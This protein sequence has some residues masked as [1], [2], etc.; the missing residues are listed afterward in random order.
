MGCYSTACAQCSE[1]GKFVIARVKVGD[2][3]KGVAGTEAAGKGWRKSSC[4][5]LGFAMQEQSG[6]RHPL[7]PFPSSL[8]RGWL[9][10]FSCMGSNLSCGHRFPC[11]ECNTTFFSRY[12]LGPCRDPCLCL[13]LSCP[14]GLPLDWSAVDWA[15]WE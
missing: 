7:S 3:W 4:R 10:I 11:G 5:N 8:P 1:L 2:K 15:G 13:H 14:C 9:R 12:G 6:S